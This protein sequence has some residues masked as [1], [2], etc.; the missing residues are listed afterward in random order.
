MF[1]VMPGYCGGGGGIPP[2][3]MVGS[4]SPPLMQMT[5]TD[6]LGRQVHSG[7]G[8]T[9]PISTRPCASRYDATDHLGPMATTINPS[10]LMRNAI[11]GWSEV[12]A[13]LTARLNAAISSC[14]AGRE[15]SIAP[16]G[17]MEIPPEVSAL[18]S[19]LTSSSTQISYASAAPIVSKTSIG[20]P[21]IS[22]VKTGNVVARFRP[23]LAASP[24]G[25]DSIRSGSRP[26]QPQLVQTYIKRSFSK[27][28]T[29]A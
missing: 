1:I 20:L 18:R 12:G 26:H 21:S 15:L 16:S 23:N 7:P 4:R 14:T 27:L 13:S 3:I 9:S 10:I 6:R 2:R 22:R 28:G 17:Q 8:T 24:I 11:V 5:D 19:D 29:T 25:G